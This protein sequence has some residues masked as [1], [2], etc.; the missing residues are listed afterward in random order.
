MARW[1][2]PRYKKGPRTPNSTPQTVVGLGIPTSRDRSSRPNSSRRRLRTGSDLAANWEPKNGAKDWVFNLRKG[3][4]F[5]NGKE[6][7]ADDAIYS[8][9]YHRGDS[10]SGGKPSLSSVTAVKK[11]RD[12]VI[13]FVPDEDRGRLEALVVALEGAEPQDEAECRSALERELRVHAYLL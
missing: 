4:K 13:P 11:A 9:N 1:T 7:N 8:L 12:R 5:S 10:K 3:V 2:L 6:F